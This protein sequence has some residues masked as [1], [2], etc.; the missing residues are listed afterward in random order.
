ML[1]YLTSKQVAE[2]EAYSQLEPFGERHRDWH[3]GKLVSMMVNMFGGKQAKE[4]A[5]SD[6]VK[7]N[8]IDYERQLSKRQAKQSGAA[9]KEFFKMFK[10]MQNG[11]D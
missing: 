9:I 2:W 11:E 4:Y 7:P 8:R 6:F 1:S 5:P 3:F 10:K